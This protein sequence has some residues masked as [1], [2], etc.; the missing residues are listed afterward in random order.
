MKLKIL[1]W[2]V[3]E[4]NDVSKRKV[5]KA[6]IRSQKADMVC[7]QET[8]MQKMSIRVVRSLGVGRFLE[9]GVVNARG[10][11]GGVVVFWDNRVLELVGMEV[12]QFSIS[13]RFK[14]CED[15]FMW[16][17]TGVY[18]PIVKRCRESLREELGAIWGLWN[19]PWCIGGD[20]NV[21]RFPYEHSRR[22]RVS[23]TIRRFLEVIDHLEL[24]DL[25]MQGGPFTW[26]G[27]LNS[28]SMSRL[29]QFLVSEDWES[30]FRG[31]A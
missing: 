4:V 15:G 26:S 8:K 12:G 9:W 2:N 6:L 27:G 3:R 19:D 28:R 20:F 24:R 21:I 18:G 5:I 31:V 25:P 14:N 7:L 30:F 1:S 22:G 11:A 23:S 29:D 17:F 13:C 10:A 16:I